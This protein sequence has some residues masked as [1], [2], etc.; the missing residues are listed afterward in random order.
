MR[1]NSLILKRSRHKVLYLDEGGQCCPICLIPCEMG[2]GF[3]HGECSGNPCAE[4]M[5]R[6][7][8]GIQSLLALNAEVDKGCL[9]RVHG[10]GYIP[11]ELEHDLGPRLLEV[12]ARGNT[13]VV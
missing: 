7:A 2:E 1:I 12:A 9:V 3:K 5:D 11:G 13:S 6:L 8:V 4:S 10:H